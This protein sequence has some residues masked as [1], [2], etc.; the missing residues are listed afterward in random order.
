MEFDVWSII[1]YAVAVV[2]LWMLG[3]L[4]DWPIKRVS[5]LIL[6]SLLGG[7]ALVIINLLGT[8][9]GFRIAINPLNALVAGVFGIPGIL[10]L[11]LLPI[12][13]S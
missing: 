10:L 11:I 12:L 4:L 6:N 13:L 9:V 7:L 3:K 8:F 2:L 5:R 1:A